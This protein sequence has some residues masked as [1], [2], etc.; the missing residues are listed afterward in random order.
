VQLAGGFIQFRTVAEGLQSA[1]EELFVKEI[2][3]LLVRVMSQL[4]GQQGVDVAA[5][6]N[7]LY[8]AA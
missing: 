6:C 2:L 5:Y 3:Q 1:C 4:D 7:A 8:V